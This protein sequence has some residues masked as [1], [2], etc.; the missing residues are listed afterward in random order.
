MFNFRYSVSRLLLAVA[1]LSP[2]CGPADLDLQQGQ[3]ALKGNCT[4]T[5]SGS[6]SGSVS[7]G[8]SVTFTAAGTCNTGTPEYSLTARQPTGYWTTLSTWSS[9]GSVNWDTTGALAGE[10]QVMA[11]VRAVG[12]GDTWEGYSSR[13]DYTITGGSG[14]CTAASITSNPLG[15]AS[16]GTTVT[17]TGSATCPGGST[18][19]YK[20]MAKDPAGMW[21]TLRNYAAS[22]TYAWDTTGWQDGWSTLAVY[23]RQAGSLVPFEAD[24]SAFY[25]LSGGV[26]YCANAALSVSPAGSVSAGTSVTL[27]ASSSCTSGAEYRFLDL[28]PSG[29]TR[30]LRNWASAATLAWDT[31]GAL[32]GGHGVYVQARLAG[33]GFAFES[34]ST[35]T[36]VTVTGGSSYC[37]GA[38]L[39]VSPSSPRA[40][41]TTVTLT[42]SATCP[43]GQ[44]SEYRFVVKGPDGLWRTAQNWSATSTYAWGTTTAATGAYTYYFY[45]RVV[46]S[47]LPYDTAAGPLA[48][49]ITGGTGTCGAATLSASPTSPVGQGT[50]VTLTG[51][52]TCTSGATAEYR[53]YGRQPDGQ[54]ALLRDWGAAAF[55]WDT[56]SVDLGGWD[57]FVHSR[58]A[59][60]SLTE[61]ISSELAFLINSDSGAAEFV[62]MST[63]GAQ[64]NGYSRLD[65]TNHH[66]SQA[67]MIS[68]DGR[69]AVF[70]SDATNLDPSFNSAG[71]YLRDRLTGTTKMVGLGTSNNLPVRFPIQNPTVSNNGRYVAF[72]TSDGAMVPGGYQRR[73]EVLL[74]DVQTG[75]TTWVSEPRSPLPI[76]TVTNCTM[77]AMA[78]DGLYVIMACSGTL[79]SSVGSGGYIYRHNIATGTLEVV[80]PGS[81]PSVS[82]D[83]RYVAFVSGTTNLVTGDT[84]GIA[85]VFVKDMTTGEVTRVSVSSSGAQTT[86][87]PYRPVVSPDGRYVTF[88][89]TDES[90]WGGTATTLNMAVM[91]DRQTGQTSLVSQTAAGVLPDSTVGMVTMAA[92]GN[93][94]FTSTATNLVSGWT[95]GVTSVYIKNISTGALTLVGPA[96]ALPYG[97]YNSPTLSKTG[98]YLLVATSCTKIVTPDINGSG[99]VVRYTVF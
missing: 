3:G 96:N 10:W 24:G 57:L 70:K 62:S 19:E 63:T 6:P 97:W 67:S 5:L 27:T 32:T 80:S 86:E 59:G 93:V 34:Q 91:H 52:A 44:T 60:S 83:G 65:Y 22:A 88:I 81:S 8:T 50:T 98:K 90:L 84:N 38:A 76:S 46:G 23:V 15:S 79:L 39:A 64:A 12:S 36:T 95:A 28:D 69:Y 48:F 2:G 1:M 92:G 18:P 53:F 68:S 43:A 74:R 25:H 29:V 11:K 94:A 45:A 66:A 16:A 99:D 20:F 33:S 14:F 30:T 9:S 13:L 73:Y 17:L 4:V 54:L 21:R 75:T 42:G 40:A 41:G 49:S 51:G 71:L 55:S 58:R 26:S 78:G 31:T 82:P 47:S 35:R 7:A 89:S 37:S 61:G 85:D 87:V 77:P 72:A 56:T